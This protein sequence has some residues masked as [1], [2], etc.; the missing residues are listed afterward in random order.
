M[1]S[2]RS[3]QFPEELTWK[4]HPKAENGFA[5][6]PVTQ[7]DLW[8]LNSLDRRKGGRKQRTGRRAS[9]WLDR[10]SRPGTENRFALWLTLKKFVGNV[11]VAHLPYV[12]DH[13]DTF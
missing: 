3:E 10:K 13:S 2:C 7:T 6:Q 11:S 12:S 4:Y 1:G 5:K 8:D 9:D